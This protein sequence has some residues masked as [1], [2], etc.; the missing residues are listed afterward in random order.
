[1]GKA[2]WARILRVVD[3]SLEIWELPLVGKRKVSSGNSLD[4]RGKT[5]DKHILSLSI[6]HTLHSRDVTAAVESQGV[7]F[8]LLL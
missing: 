4:M 5:R 7:N 3:T 8:L 1:M 6:S 2:G